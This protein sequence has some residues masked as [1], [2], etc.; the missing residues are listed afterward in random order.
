MDNF[1]EAFEQRVKNDPFLGKEL[2][3]ALNSEPPTSIR[4]NPNKTSEY[5]PAGNKI[6]WC[7]DALYMEHRPVYTLDPLFHAGAYYP[8][9]AGSMVLAH[10]LEQLLLPEHPFCLDLCAAPGGKSTLIASYLKG[11][12]ILVANEINAH[13]SKIL[14]EN[15]SKWGF[16]N[17]VVTNN[18]PADFQTLYHFFDL[19]LADVPCSG[20]GMF[21][22]DKKSRNEWSVQNVEMCT[23][24]QRRIIEEIW[25]SLKPEGYLIYSTCTLN[26]SENEE[27]ITW[28]M[29]ELGAEIIEIDLDKEFFNGRNDIG[30][31]AI[32]GKT[33]AEGF[34]FAVLKKK[35][36]T[37]GILKIKTIS[38]L[39]KLSPDEFRIYCHTD[40]IDFFKWKDRVLALPKNGKEAMFQLMNSLHLIKLGTTIA[41]SNGKTYVPDQELANNSPLCAFAD[42]IELTKAHAL[43]YLK[44]ETFYLEGSAGYKL[45][46]YNKIPLGWIKHLGNRF[47]NLYPKEWRIRMN[48]DKADE[49]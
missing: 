36:E 34:Y 49:F 27:N 8:Q 13:R 43:K 15:I 26:A 29:E 30:Y 7:E 24:R 10:V 2:L 11:N 35:T 22:K 6:P 47:N 9:E 14:R 38:S 5:M 45:M 4:I 25:Q 17:S 31:Y 18:K 28:I 1:P 20:E 39:Q 21:R 33:N 12:G 46:C 19:V 16:T 42:R 37:S 32:P 3:D 40:G 44:G 48:I 23:L 41:I